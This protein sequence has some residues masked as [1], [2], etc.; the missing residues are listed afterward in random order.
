MKIK[1]N[2]CFCCNENSAKHYVG[3]M[4][5]I[6]FCETCLNEQPWLIAKLVEYETY[7]RAW[8]E[9]RRF[10]Y[11]EVMKAYEAGQKYNNQMFICK[12]LF[13]ENNSL[14]GDEI[15]RFQSEY[16][17]LFIKE[18]MAPEAPTSEEPKT[19][20]LQTTSIEDALRQLKRIYKNNQVCMYEILAGIEIHGLTVE[21]IMTVY[22]KAMALSDGDLM[23]IIKEGQPTLIS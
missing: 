3:D 16:D 8:C 10:P 18:I 11:D 20:I 6:G 9:H 17:L 19:P 1:L 12:D 22:A 13:E 23:I 21:E 4:P 5:K 7:K 14:F 2:R 15:I